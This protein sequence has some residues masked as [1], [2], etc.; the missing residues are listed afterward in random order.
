MAI[1][2]R[3]STFRLAEV[4]DFGN[5]LQVPGLGGTRRFDSNTELVPRPR[6][7]ENHH[8]CIGFPWVVI[9]GHG[10]DDIQLEHESKKSQ[11]VGIT[12]CSTEP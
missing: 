12:A 9:V 5:L 10:L 6:T 1:A 2:F 7:T 11:N 3:L 8:I 4:I